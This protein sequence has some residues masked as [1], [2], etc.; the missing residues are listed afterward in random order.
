MS[1]FAING[2]FLLL[3]LGLLSIVGSFLGSFVIWQ[4]LSF[5]GEALAHG[6]LF[7]AALGL[8]FKIPAQPLYT[9]ICLCLSIGYGVFSLRS[10]HKLKAWQSQFNSLSHGLL[11]VGLLLLGAL[12]QGLAQGEMLLFGD[13]LALDRGEGVQLSIIYIAMLLVLLG[14]YRSFLSFSVSPELYGVE[15][16]RKRLIAMILFGLLGLFVGIS[17]PLVGAFLLVGTLIL[18]ASTAN[19]LAKTPIG[20]VLLAVLLSLFGVL[21]G[22]SLSLWEDLPLGPAIISAHLCI[23]LMVLV[24]REVYNSLRH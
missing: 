20:M 11:G 17:L 1:N 24:F 12:P 9:G 23:F 5:V 15:G 13:I 21:S 6:A 10:H 16:G 7:G 3:P 14:G 18:P 22:F 8:Y 2:L 4:R 19:L